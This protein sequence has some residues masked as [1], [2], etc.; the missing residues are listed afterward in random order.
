[1]TQVSWAGLGCAAGRALLRR[2]GVAGRAPPGPATP[3][4]ARWVTIAPARDAVLR[5]Q[6]HASVR[7]RVRASRWG[8]RRMA[9]HAD[10]RALAGGPVHSDRRR[11]DHFHDLADFHQHAPVSDAGRLRVARRCKARL[12]P[13]RLAHPQ[14]AAPC[15]RVLFRDVIVLERA[16][17][18][19]R[20]G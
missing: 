14:K 16:L 13:W 11:T 4:S 9:V 2:P 6:G 8:S 10:A 12:N 18:R 5:L 17:F 1:M 7:S 15:G 20:A 19:A 3:V